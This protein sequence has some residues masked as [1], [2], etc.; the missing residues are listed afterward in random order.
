ME[1]RE[2]YDNHSVT[3][4]P[5]HRDGLY[6]PRN[7]RCLLWQSAF[8]SAPGFEQRFAA[9]FWVLLLKR[10]GLFKLAV[11]QYHKISRETAQWE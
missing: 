10:R 7:T 2:Q 4:Y 9:G 1:G 3:P 8:D 5:H 6:S 11:L